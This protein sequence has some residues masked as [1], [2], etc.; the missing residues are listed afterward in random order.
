MSSVAKH[1]DWAQAEPLPSDAPNEPLNRT[2]EKLKIKA[3]VEG[4]TY[5]FPIVIRV[6]LVAGFAAFAH[7]LLAL[8]SITSVITALVIVYICGHPGY[9][10]KAVR[11]INN[12]ACKLKKK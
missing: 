6:L 12:L 7:F 3:A 11:H 9:T 5:T 10:V 2:G 8:N 4:E 1:Q